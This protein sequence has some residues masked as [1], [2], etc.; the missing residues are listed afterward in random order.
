MVLQAYLRHRA[1]ALYDDPLEIP[2]GVAGAGGQVIYHASAFDG[3]GYVFRIRDVA[4]DTLNA[5]R[6]PRA[7]R[8]RPAEHPHCGAPLGEGRHQLASDEATPADYDNIRRE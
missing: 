7:R 5:W 1:S 3:G 8:H 4:A 6:G 2:P